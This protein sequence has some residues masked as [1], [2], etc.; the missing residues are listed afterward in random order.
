M[1]RR[2]GRL[3]GLARLV[4]PP[5]CR[6]QLGVRCQSTFPEMVPDRTEMLIE[7]NELLRREIAALRLG[8]SGTDEAAEVSKFAGARS[9]YTTE[10]KFWYPHINSPPP[11]M[12][13]FRI[14]DD[15][16]RVVP[17]AEPHVPEM[18]R[19]LAVAVVRVAPPRRALGPA[20]ANALT[21][22]PRRP[23]VLTC[24]PSGRV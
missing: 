5:P 9:V 8:A 17:G 10:P 21:H 16:G 20:A 7:E 2:I 14:M 12:P 6:R 23:S 24:P 18:S 15:I 11:T 22:D 3:S 4:R 1:Q 13:C 19:E